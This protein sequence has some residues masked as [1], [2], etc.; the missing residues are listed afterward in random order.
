M[1]K[2]LIPYEVVPADIDE[3]VYDDTDV[4]ERVVALARDKCRIVAE[5][6]PDRFVV[7]ADTL[8]A[9]KDGAVFTKPKPGSDPLDAAMELSGRT[10]EVYTGCCVYSP[11]N[12]YSEKLA[13]ATITYQKF[14]RD[15]LEILA[16]GD[17]PQ[18]RSG[19]LG[20]FVD[21]PGFTLI[22]NIAGSYTGMYGLPMEFIYDQLDS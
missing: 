12:G 16:E 15:R 13:T 22:D 20:V 8:T 3:T 19:A 6:Y 4:Q 11:K 14:T 9:D 7:A 17:S 1:E 2:S 21:A 10:I 18:I 5:K